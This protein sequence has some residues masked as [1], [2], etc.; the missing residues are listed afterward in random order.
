M[1]KVLTSRLIAL[2]LFLLPMP[3]MHRASA[4]DSPPNADDLQ[5]VNCR[6]PVRV[7][8]IGGMTRTIPG[9]VVRTTAVDCRVR[10][11]LDLVRK[12]IPK[13]LAGLHALPCGEARCYSSVEV[14]EAV[15][16]IR[17]QVR[18]VLPP[19][20]IALA[21]A[22]DAKLDRASR[23]GEPLPLN[24]IQPARSRPDNAT[25]GHVTDQVA[26]VFQKM[27]EVIENVLNH[28]SLT[29]TLT[30]SSNPDS[31]EF[32]IHCGGVEITKRRGVTNQPLP[33]VWRG[34]YVIEMRKKGYK[35][36]IRDH[37]DLI[38]DGHTHIVC[39]LASEQDH[40]DS[41]CRQQ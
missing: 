8:R 29:P 18:E 37:I 30:I 26:A 20:A 4:Q 23:L 41:I 5:M 7:K 38:D 28:D 32:V 24:A 27:G 22:I 11:G 19:Q 3:G 34:V 9:R 40:N 10:G 2:G 12:S 6:L 39:D 17:R 35:P 36:G 14:A 16:R 13:S 33:N 15:E 25:T 21:L 1:T 31:A